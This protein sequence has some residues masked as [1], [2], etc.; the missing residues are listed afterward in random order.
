M[1]TSDF[2][3]DVNEADFEYEVL[4]YSKNVPVVVEFWATWCRPCKVL[5]PMLE[6]MTKE[7][8]GAFRLARIDSDQNPNLALQ[9]G[10]RTIPTVKAITGGQVMGEFTG[11]IPEER[12][13]EFISKI[14]PPSHLQL[15]AEKVEGLLSLHQ[16]AEAEKIYRQLL[17]QTADQPSSLLGLSKALL[18]QNKSGE[19]LAILRNFPASRLYSTVDLLLPYAQDLVDLGRNALRDETDLDM[20]YRTAIRLA[21]RGNFPAALDGMLD[22]LRKDKNYRRG[23]ARQIVVGLLELMG[24]DDPLTREYRS[25][26]ASVLY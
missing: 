5:G 20:A 24:E 10:V 9:F 2:I 13:R 17:E 1:M 21:S 23:R 15:L 12:L 11:L 26:L 19:A 8:N 25:E 16:Y 14:T 18:M 7:A 6:A 4:S 3:V 22:I